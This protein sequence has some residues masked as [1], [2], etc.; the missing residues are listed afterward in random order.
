MPCSRRAPAVRQGRGRRWLSWPLASACGVDNGKGRK[1]DPQ[2]NDLVYIRPLLTSTACGTCTGSCLTSS[3]T[4]SALRRILQRFRSVLRFVGRK[5]LKPAENNSQTPGG[6]GDRKTFPNSTVRKPTAVG[7]ASTEH[8]AKP[9]LCL[10]HGQKRRLC[11]STTTSA[12]PATFRLALPWFPP[13][14]EEQLKQKK[15]D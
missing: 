7:R 4:R 2:N 15:S 10:C 8:T 11:F 9:L 12:N 6:A 13:M 1:V 14:G 5:M 3:A